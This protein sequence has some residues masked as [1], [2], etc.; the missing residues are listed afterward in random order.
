VPLRL[1]WLLKKSQITR[2]WS[3]PSRTK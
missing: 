2:Y 3:N 1:S